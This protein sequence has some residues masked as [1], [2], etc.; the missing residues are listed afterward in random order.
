[1]PSA[2]TDTPALDRRETA[3]W[4]KSPSE[5]GS[6]G[7]YA[8]GGVAGCDCGVEFI[9]GVIRGGTLGTGL[10]PAEDTELAGECI[11]R[12]GGGGRLSAF[13]PVVFTR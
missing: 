7:E 9:R 5:A 1:M 2:G 11:L 3:L 10:E 6:D 4:F 12:A 13:I 8:G